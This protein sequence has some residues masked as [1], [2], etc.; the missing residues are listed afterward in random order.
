MLGAKDSSSKA[1]ML[2]EPNQTLINAIDKCRN[3]EIANVQCKAMN[4]VQDFS[5][6]NY[7]RKEKKIIEAKKLDGLVK[8]VKKIKTVVK[9]RVNTVVESTKKG[10]NNVQLIV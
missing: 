1:R 10:R 3:S 9:S 6:L 7:V 8:R 4:G 2:R 5:A